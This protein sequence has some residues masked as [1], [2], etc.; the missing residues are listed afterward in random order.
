MQAANTSRCVLPITD[1]RRA[2]H[3]VE[4]MRRYTATSAASHVA[5]SLVLM[6]LWGCG[7]EVATPTHTGEAGMP[8]ASHDVGPSDAKSDASQDVGTNDAGADVDA[9]MVD[10][11]PK[12]ELD[13][14]QVVWHYDAPDLDV[15]HWPIT[16][17]LTVTFSGSG[18]SKT[19]CLNN[20]K[21]D[22]WPAPAST[23]LKPG[24]KGV[25]GSAWVILKHDDGKWHGLI[26]EWMPPENVCKP[27]HVVNSCPMKIPPFCGDNWD[28]E[29]GEELYFMVS[30]LARLG[31][32]NVS[33][34][35][36]AVRVTWPGHVHCVCPHTCSG[37]SV[38]G[39]CP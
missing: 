2:L 37:G 12:D 35:T 6:M 16:T 25:I 5:P 39:G 1:S 21:A 23:I 31:H 3:R 18:L 34:R 22:V 10:A 30:G 24:G 36:N 13:L 26:W 4:S 9:A 17:P 8:D 29:V 7:S 33:E 28:P 27:A 38:A 15:H 14:D 11:G 20:D 32:R 19:L